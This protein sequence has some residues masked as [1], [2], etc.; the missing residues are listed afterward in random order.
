M[1]T[2]KQKYNKEKYAKK[3][4][5]AR[6]AYKVRKEYL[7][8]KK[9]NRDLVAGW[10]EEET[11]ESEDTGSAVSEPDGGIG[12][13][14]GSGELV[15]PV[16]AKSYRYTSGY[17]RRWG[18]MHWG[19]DLGPA[20][21]GA[22]NCKILAAGDG[23]V[24]AAGP[25]GGFGQWIVI[26]H[27]DKL[28]TIYGH[29]PKSSMKVKIGDRVKKGQH[30]ALMGDEGESQGVHLH[31]ETTRDFRN[32]KGKG[33][34]GK[35]N[36]FDPEEMVD[37][38]SGMLSMTFTKEIAE[39]SDFKIAANASFQEEAGHEGEEHMHADYGNLIEPLPPEGK[40]ID[41]AYRESYVYR[42]IASGSSSLTREA[43]L[44]E[45]IGWGRTTNYRGYHHLNK[46]RFVH[47][48]I[49]D[50][51]EGNLY[52]PDAKNVFES[53]LLKTKKP[54]FEIV[55]GFRYSESGQLSPH[56]AGCAM[57]ILVGDIDEVR[58]IAD[59]AWLLGIRSI[60]IG[61]NFEQNKGFVHLDIA[62]K[63]KDFSY[64]GIPIYGGPGKW[65]MK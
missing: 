50:G 65:V 38:R 44:Y 30:I 17:G 53:L 26:K 47:Q 3:L 10:E 23:V 58:E 61:G 64:D 16:E 5:D 4:K 46:K 14:V 56:E 1:A 59:C 40:L 2:D 19:V 13:F 21:K 54:Y 62:P 11:A 29:M 60:A 37:I 32:R 39:K 15:A 34:D 31:F 18:T 20:Q 24:V 42:P 28:Y 45:R 27:S 41:Q 49:Y 8:T 25:A 33:K 63:G 6:E 43:F 9:L 7:S 22:R 51:Y 36:T 12:N 55:S 57:D 35:Y 52:S 48:G